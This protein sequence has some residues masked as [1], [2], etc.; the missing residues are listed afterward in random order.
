MNIKL[1]HPVDS[2]TLY[3]DTMQDHADADD[4][5]IERLERAARDHIL[6]GQ[7]HVGGLDGWVMVDWT[8]L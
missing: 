5:V 7:G 2:A 1:R 8:G 3:G 6:M 4:G